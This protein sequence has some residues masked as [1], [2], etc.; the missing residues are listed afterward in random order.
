MTFDVTGAQEGDLPD[1]PEE[2]A[3]LGSTDQLA[4]PTVT[5]GAF[6]IS[7]I[8][9]IIFGLYPANAENKARYEADK[10]AG[11]A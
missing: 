2:G 11:R 5:A 1:Q 7:V 3:A 8:L 6:L 9:G 4:S 10:A